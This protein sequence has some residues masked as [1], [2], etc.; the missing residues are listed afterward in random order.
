MNPAPIEFHPLYQSFWWGAGEHST[1][2]F[3]SMKLC[4]G[5]IVLSRFS[6]PQGGCGI[7]MEHGI[8][9]VIVSTVAIVCKPFRE[10][11]VTKTPNKLMN[12]AWFLK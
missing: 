10:Q 12:C 6:Q 1:L 8:R 3:Y 9:K 7:L 4:I 5:Y 11:G 2:I